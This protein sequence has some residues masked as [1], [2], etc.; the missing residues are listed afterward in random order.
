MKPKTSLTP[1]QKS[2]R[3]RKGTALLQFAVVFPVFFVFILG[4]IEFGRANMVAS[5]LNNAA[6]NGCRVACLSGKSN[7]DVTNSISTSLASQ[8]IR[9]YTT[10]IKI[11]DTVANAS[12]ANSGDKI[13]VIV[14]VTTANVTWI[15]GTGLLKGS[16]TGKCTL[17]RE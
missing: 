1:A 16:L 11:N 7:T 12:T 14:A 8:G 10:S 6:R 3:V 9:N 2:K 17:Y 4:F 13:T 5:L 15:P